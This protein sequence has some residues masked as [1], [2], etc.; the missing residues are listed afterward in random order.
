MANRTR[1][2]DRPLRILLGDSPIDWSVVKTRED[3]FP[4]LAMRDSFPAAL[5]QT[6]VLARRRKAL[7]VYGTMHFQR[8]QVMANYDMSDWRMQ[9]IVSL[10]ERSTPAR[11]FTIWDIDDELG[12]IVPGVATWKAPALA[13]TR[14]TSLGAADFAAFVPNRPRMALK[15]GAFVPLPR[16]QWSALPVEEQVDAVLYLGPKATMVEVPARACAEPGFLEER[17]RRIALGGIPAF[18]ADRLE[19]ICSG[20]PPR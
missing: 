9:T 12:A 3:L 14:G 10:I 20:G 17:L 16:E 13:T 19:R 11:V 1:P 18:E 2:R 15:D 6:Q 8:R 7:I 5:V 4:W